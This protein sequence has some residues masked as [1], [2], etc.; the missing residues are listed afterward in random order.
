VSNLYY[1]EK[2]SVKG[3]LNSKDNKPLSKSRDLSVNKTKTI[4]LS[5]KVADM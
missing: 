4:G 1:Y 2:E 5:C 3:R